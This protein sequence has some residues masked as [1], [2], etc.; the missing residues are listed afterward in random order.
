MGTRA[1]FYLGRGEDATWLGSLLAEAR[2]ENI[3]AAILE[4]REAGDF[5]ARVRA[6]LSSAGGLLAEHGWPWRWRHSGETGYT[7]AFDGE[8]TLVGVGNRW[9]GWRGG[10]L[11]ASQDEHYRM[12]DMVARLERSGPAAVFR[13]KCTTANIALDD[14]KDVRIAAW[15]FLIVRLWLL[16]WHV[17]RI[18]PSGRLGTLRSGVLESVDEQYLMLRLANLIAEPEGRRIFAPEAVGDATI[19]YCVAFICRMIERGWHRTLVGHGQPIDVDTGIRE[20]RAQPSRLDGTIHLEVRLFEDDAVAGD[21]LAALVSAAEIFP[22]CA[23][24]PFQRLAEDN[25]WTC[26]DE[27]VVNDQVRTVDGRNALRRH[28]DPVFRKLLLPF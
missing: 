5:E 20:R 23:A 6:F 15:G 18:P 3:P 7:Y 14:T 17:V 25:G 28:M 26:P 1:D 27:E 22:P 11:T 2:P 9:H 21:L 8:R 4:A 10:R 19:D 13:W 16:A 12:P 24:R